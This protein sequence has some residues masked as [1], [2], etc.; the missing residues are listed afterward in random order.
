MN[1]AILY[2]IVTQGKRRYRSSL[3]A[4]QAEATRRAILES[5]YE[6]FTSKGFAMTSMRA[7]AE[8]AGVSEPTVYN[9]FGDKVGLLSAVG[10]SYTDLSGGEADLAFLD[11]LRAEPDPVERL[12]MAAR[13]SRQTWESGATELE[14]MVFNPQVDDPRLVELARIGLAYKQANMRATFEIMYP[15][16]LR[17]PGLDLDTIVAFATAI[18]SAATVTTLVKLGWSMD[19]W[20]AWVVEFLLLFY[21]P[22]VVSG[23]SDERSR[24]D[25]ITRAA[26]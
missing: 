7:V 21:D 20:E 15:E 18:D 6:L 23:L 26:L 14:M 13:A 17:R 1:R 16:E 4:R 10:A 2:A 24:S 22:A 12:R 25:R 9:A 19:D 8:R 5:A 11:A 3:R